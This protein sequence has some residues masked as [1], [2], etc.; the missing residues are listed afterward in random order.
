MLTAALFTRAK[1]WKQ[2][3]CPQKEGWIKRMEH[4]SAVRKKETL[5]LTVTGMNLEDIMLSEISQTG[6]DKYCIV[7]LLCGT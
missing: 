4:Y 1:M 2:P 5:P 7:S 6:R 3:K